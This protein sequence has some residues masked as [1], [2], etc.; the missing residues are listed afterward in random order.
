MA[1][2]LVRDVPPPSRLHHSNCPV[3]SACGGRTAI[4]RA[5]RALQGAPDRP[6]PPQPGGVTPARRSLAKESNAWCRCHDPRFAARAVHRSTPDALSV[7]ETPGLDGGVLRGAPWSATRSQDDGDTTS[8]DEIAAAVQVVEPRLRRNITDHRVPLHTQ[9]SLA[10]KQS[11]DVRP[12]ARPRPARAATTSNAALSFLPRAA[13]SRECAC[14]CWCRARR[15]RRVP[16][17][18]RPDRGP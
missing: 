6:S 14:G 7:I 1:H 5:A 16:R 12:A 9:Y 3:N 10:P 13:A 11:R 17:A 4:L 15:W 8:P 18:R 2:T